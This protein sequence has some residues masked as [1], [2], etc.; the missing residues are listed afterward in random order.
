MLLVDVGA[1]LFGCCEDV[2]KGA[3]GFGF[4]FGEGRGDDFE[5]GEADLREELSSSGRGRCQDD[6]FP[7]DHV[8]CWEVQWQWR[9]RSR[10]ALLGRW[11][12]SG[13][14]SDSAGGIV[15]GR[16]I[17][18]YLFVH[19]G[20]GGGGIGGGGALTCEGELSIW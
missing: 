12:G 11:R 14:D 16:C 2:F 19:H 7:T 17:E 6:S 1:F 20:G 10:W 5:V 15:G 4:V 8:E 9:S 3:E 13:R 18:G